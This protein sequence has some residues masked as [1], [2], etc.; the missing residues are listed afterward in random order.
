M[1]APLTHLLMPPQP[2]P[3]AL[4]VLR[5]L[6][7]EQAAVL[8][9]SAEPLQS[10]APPAWQVPPLQKSLTVQPLPSLQLPDLG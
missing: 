1:H 7:P 2:V 4:A 6:P 8:Q 5:Q 10:L 9:A 3:L